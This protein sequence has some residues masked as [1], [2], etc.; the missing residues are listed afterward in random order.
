M[1]VNGVRVPC[2]GVR[3]IVTW[4]DDPRRAPRV[5][6]GRTRTHPPVAVV[7]HTTRGREGAL[8]DGPAP[9]STQ[10]ETLALYQS[11]TAR[12]VS[13]HLTVDTDGTVLQQADLVSWSCWHAGH[14][15]G[16]TIGVELVQRADGAVYVSQLDT[17]VSLVQAICDVT[18]IPRRVP[19][20]RKG[21]PLRV[22]V[23]AWRSPGASRPGLGERWPGVIGHR[24]LTDDRGPGDP[25][26]AVFRALLAAGFEAHVVS[27]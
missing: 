18:A 25:G 15:N 2:P 23:A 13:W 6:D 14:A 8:V 10:A 1:I 4:L 26:D 27:A 3:E 24:N 7:L 17:A 22:S 9:A 20:D 16:W 12:E 21:A 19:V 11:R 5:T